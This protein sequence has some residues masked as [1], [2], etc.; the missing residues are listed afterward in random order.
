MSEE[1]DILN[2][3]AFKVLKTEIERVIEDRIK[4]QVLQSLLKKFRGNE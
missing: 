3:E 2:A 4:K 1:T